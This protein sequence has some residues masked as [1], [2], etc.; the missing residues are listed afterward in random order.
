[1]GQAFE[2]KG[3]KENEGVLGT[4]LSPAVI[5]STKCDSRASRA[6]TSG[7]QVRG[8]REESGRRA[9]RDI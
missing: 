5:G 4:H 8:P 2:G 1:M 9:L 7:E 6:K 3:G